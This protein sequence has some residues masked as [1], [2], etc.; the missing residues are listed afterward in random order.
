MYT[1]CVCTIL[2][3]GMLLAQARPTMPCIRLVIIIVIIIITILL[4]LL[5]SV[6]SRARQKV[7][8]A[9]IATEPSRRFISEYFSI[10]GNDVIDVP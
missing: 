1:N 5:L 3:L 4:L 10:M 2:V 9:E 6:C 8:R 7:G